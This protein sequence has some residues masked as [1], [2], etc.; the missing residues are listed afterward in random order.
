M[1]LTMIYQQFYIIRKGDFATDANKKIYYSLFTICLSLEEYIN[2]GST[3]CF[4]IMIGSTMIWTLIETILY[5]TNTRVIKPMYITGPLKNNF[6]IPK[7]VA[8]FLQ[9]FQ[10][11]GVV[12]TFG[13]YFG[14]RLRQIRYF[15]LFHLFITYIIINMNSKQNISNVASKR[16]INTVGS[17]LT[18]S[19]I[20]IYNLITLYQHPQNFQRQFN[21]FFVMTYVCSIWTYIAYKKGFRTTETVIINGDEITVK[22]E[23]KVDSFFI[24]GYDIVFEISIAYITFYNLFILNS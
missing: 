22:P 2:T 18:M 20:S 14:D 10:E 23:S 6:L 17:L 16:Q 11:G 8:L 5:I 15:I 12:T 24:L 3:D 9:G 21:M 7:Y 13:L 19:S 1:I 4:R